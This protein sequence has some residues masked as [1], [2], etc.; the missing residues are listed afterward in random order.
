M[1]LLALE[2]EDLKYFDRIKD[3]EE[4]IEFL[5]SGVRVILFTGG[6][7]IYEVWSQRELQDQK[8]LHDEGVIAKFEIYID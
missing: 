8:Q 1:R 3:L 7:E 6:R 4:A 5:E 2:P